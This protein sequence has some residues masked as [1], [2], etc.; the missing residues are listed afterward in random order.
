MN[1][2]NL[3][4]LCTEGY[5][6]SKVST[7]PTTYRGFTEPLPLHYNLCKVCCSDYAGAEEWSKN[8]KV[9]MEFHARVDDLLKEIDV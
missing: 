1:Q 3:C 5:T 2:D 4:S 9:V 6:Q 7:V 8:R